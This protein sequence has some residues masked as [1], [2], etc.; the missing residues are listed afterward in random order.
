MPE[1][2][3][4]RPLSPANERCLKRTLGCPLPEFVAKFG[5]DEAVRR[6]KAELRSA[7][8]ARSRKLHAL[9][10]AVLARIDHGRNEDAI[11]AKRATGRR[12]FGP[13]L[14]RQS[15]EGPAEAAP[16]VISLASTPGPSRPVITP[17]LQRLRMRHGR[18]RARRT[19][20]IQP[21]RRSWVRCRPLSEP[22]EDPCS[23]S[24]QTGPNGFGEG[25]SDLD[26]R[27]A[28]ARSDRGAR[29]ERPRRVSERRIDRLVGEISPANNGH[30]L[31][32]M[33]AAGSNSSNLV[34]D[35]T[36]VFREGGGSANA[37]EQ[38]RRREAIR[39]G[40]AGGSH[41]WGS[42]RVH[43]LSHL[44]DPFSPADRGPQGS[45][46]PACP[47]GYARP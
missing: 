31:E 17:G 19:G 38:G 18:Q 47:L 30:P 7:K 40:I 3:C 24:P 32:G 33:S 5:A 10:S 2:D 13:R 21:V 36:E 25:G 41:A 6:A 34:D 46:S 15:H 23:L 16:A 44:D 26:G 29:D 11:G 28:E 4:D 43:A 12:P 35:V 39:I 8:R 1:I 14:R 45:P 20:M 9:W 27:V 42:S 37:L 22:A